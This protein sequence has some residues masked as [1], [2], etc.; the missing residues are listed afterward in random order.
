GGGVENVAGG[1]SGDRTILRE[2]QGTNRGQKR[3]G[4]ESHGAYLGGAV[5]VP[6]PALMVDGGVTGGVLPPPCCVAYT[7]PPAAA[8][9]TA[10]STAMSWPCPA[11]A[12]TVP[13]AV[14]TALL[15]AM[16]VWAVWPR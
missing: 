11:P 5:T 1:R 13:A 15:C 4:V 9:P 6:G 16:F 14:R 7:M 3:K 10:A 8:A 12:A 2:C